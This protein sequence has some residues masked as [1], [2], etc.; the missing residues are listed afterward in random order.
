MDL[1]SSNELHVSVLVLAAGEG[2]RM[3]SHLPKV[4]HRISGQALI[5]YVLQLIE[6]FSSQTSIMIDG[7]SHRIFVDDVVVV[8]SEEV[9]KHKDFIAIK[10]KYDHD[11]V[12][13]N[14]K[15]GTGGA[16]CVAIEHIESKN[17]NSVK[18][19]G[20]AFASDS[21]SDKNDIYY[22]N[23]SSAVLVLYGDTPFISLETVNSLLAKKF[24]DYKNSEDIF[25]HF[26]NPD[27]VCAGFKAD[28]DC[29]G[30]GRFIIDDQDNKQI[31]GI[32]EFQ[33]LVEGEKLNLSGSIVC[34]DEICNSGIMVA[35]YKLFS[36]FIQNQKLMKDNIS[37]YG[38]FYLTSL[39]DY[40]TNHHHT[41]VYTEIQKYEAMGVNNPRQKA[42]AE[43]VM[44]NKL[45]RNMLDNGVTLVSPET[46]FLSFDTKIGHGSTV[47]PYVWFGPDVI[48]GNDVVVQSFSHIEGA[49]I[50][51]KAKIGPFA[52]IR[53]NSKIGEGARIGNFAEVKNSEFKKGATSGHMSYIGDATI[54]VDTNIGAGTVFCNYDGRE[55]HHTVVG[56]RVFIGSNSEIISPIKIGDDSLIGA[57]T[58]VTHNVDEGDLV[59]SRVEQKNIKNKGK[60]L[61]KDVSRN[62]ET[63]EKI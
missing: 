53:P 24:A 27:V 51:N 58:T 33:N 14:V 55:K 21:S 59:V 11:Y 49:K 5:E 29:G 8:I 37:K 19:N 22:K 3:L 50:S 47:Y 34:T 63:L 10:K 40:A 15:N 62:K 7:V 60:R 20:V 48:I 9:Q 56:D 23:P 18:K 6:N 54:G 41:V 45:R 2:K 17:K 42:E 57:G 43:I 26:E 36:T 28:S 16:A 13:Q 4:L 32:V 46:I 38:E 35:D 30:Y 25:V 1:D 52:R 61:T 44:Q 39:V 12:I 31:S